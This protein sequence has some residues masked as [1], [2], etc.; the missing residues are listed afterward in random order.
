MKRIPD[1]FIIRI[2]RYES[3]DPEAIVGTCEKVGKPPQ[4]FRTV[5]QLLDILKPPR[6]GERPKE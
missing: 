2:Y 6:A 1:T 4:S 5:G 3:Q